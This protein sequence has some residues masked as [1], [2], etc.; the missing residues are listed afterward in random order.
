V[1]LGGDLEN[2]QQHSGAATS[3][4]LSSTTLV[5]KPNLFY[6]SSWNDK[7]VDHIHS[8][9]DWVVIQVEYRICCIL[10]II[11]CRRGVVVV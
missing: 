5:S 9:F 3:R 10:D 7:I 1:S 4:V 11:V 6:R 8:I 2:P